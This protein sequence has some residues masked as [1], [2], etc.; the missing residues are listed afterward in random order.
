MIEL[1]DYISNRDLTEGLSF[2]SKLKPEVC[3]SS[4][5]LKL[6][7]REIFR[8]LDIIDESYSFELQ[9]ICNII[10]AIAIQPREI[11]SNLKLKFD[12]HLR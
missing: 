7:L 1:C 8:S 6:V 3:I 9:N 5:C 10:F 11:T 2:K 4:R 12:S